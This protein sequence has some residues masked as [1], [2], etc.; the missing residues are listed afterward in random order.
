MGYSHNQMEVHDAAEA[1]TRGAFEEKGLNWVESMYAKWE[2]A[3]CQTE[4]VELALGD[5]TESSGRRSRNG[6]DPR[7]PGERLE[8]PTFYNPEPLVPSSRILWR[9]MQ[10]RVDQLN[11]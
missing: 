7:Q 8:A 4:E 6:S 5:P 2:N 9:A 11:N 3:E 10:R 1:E